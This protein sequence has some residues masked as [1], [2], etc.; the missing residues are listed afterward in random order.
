MD[1]DSG[2]EIQQVQYP[3]DLNTVEVK[4]PEGATGGAI[5][6]VE[7]DLEFGNF[8]LHLELLEL[9]NAVAF[10]GQIMRTGFCIVQYRAMRL[11]DR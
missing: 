3:L 6:E 5:I 7:H 1:Y 9:S 4:R 11:G 8:E 10:L 2:G